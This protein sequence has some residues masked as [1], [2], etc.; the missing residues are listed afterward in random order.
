M[1]NYKL[2]IEYDGTGYHGWQRQKNEPTVQAEIEHALAVMTRKKVVLNGS[3]RTDAGVHA[4]AQTANF[5][6]EA[7]LS[8]EAFQMGLNSLLKADIVI[9][10][11][12]VVDAEF[13]ARYAAR[14][15]VYQYRI[16]NSRIPSAIQRHW[17]WHIRKE[18]DF[19]AMQQA[20]VHVVGSHDFKAFEGVGSPRSTTVRE[21]ARAEITRDSAGNI[22]FSIEADGFLRYMVRN[23]VGTLVEVGR[24]KMTPEVF[25]TVLESR[26]RGNAGATA[27]PQGLFLVKVLY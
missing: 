3:G 17:V 6:S 16:L 5:R 19:Y 4:L 22:Y 10:D 11:C 12:R 7:G 13:H 27:P 9:K 8:A 26:H 2:V 14:G 18:L 1:K 23:I 15:K 21:V 20:A 24:S 25:K